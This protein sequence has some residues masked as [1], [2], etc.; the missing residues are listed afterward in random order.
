MWFTAINEL[1][2]FVFGAAALWFGILKGRRTLGLVLFFLS[3]ISKEPAVMFLPLFWLVAPD[4]K[5]IEP[6]AVLA[7]VVTGSIFLTR[8]ANNFRFTD[9]S[10]SMSAPFWFTW[11]RGV[12]RVL[13]IWGWI[14]A[15]WIW[16]RGDAKHREGALRALVW[17]ALSLVPYIFVTYTTQIPS[18][19]TY[20][21]TF[22]LSILVGLAMESVTRRSLVAVAA[23][24]MLVH[25]VAILWDRKRTQFL[26]R[27]APTEK[28]MDLARTTPGPIW[29][30]CFPRTDWIAKEAVRLGAGRAPET[31]LV[32][33]EAEAREK[34]ATAVFCSR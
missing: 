6:Y 34:G 11:P 15:V 8:G 7:V 9:G 28:L 21:A 33:S 25:N 18:R 30:Q 14:A 29:V 3:L 24:A 32:W 22:G 12:H 13:W 2:M 5:K 10:F 4:W 26:E 19:Q 23:A 17:I 20:L 27:A 31:A 1:W 16:F